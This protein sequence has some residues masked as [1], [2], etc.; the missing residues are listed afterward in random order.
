MQTMYEISQIKLML[1]T[2][3]VNICWRTGFWRWDF[4]TSNFSHKI[5]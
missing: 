2:P 3:T 1:M 4:F 5:L